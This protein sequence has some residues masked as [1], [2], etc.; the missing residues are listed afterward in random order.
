MALTPSSAPLVAVGLTSIKLRSPVEKG[1]DT[2]SGEAFEVLN[3][4]DFI[5]PLWDRATSHTSIWNDGYTVNK[6]IGNQRVPPELQGRTYAFVARNRGWDMKT[7][8]YLQV[9]FSYDCEVYVLLVNERAAV[10]PWVESKFTKISESKM[11]L[12]VDWHLPI[13]IKMMALMSQKLQMCNRAHLNRVQAELEVQA[14]CDELEAFRRSYG[15]YEECRQATASLELVLLLV[16]QGAELDEVACRY[17]L[18]KVAT[19]PE[20]LHGAG[21][22]DLRHLMLHYVYSRRRPVSSTLALAKVLDEVAVVRKAKH[23]EY[24]QVALTLRQL[25]MALVEKLDALEAAAA[26][27]AGNEAGAAATTAAGARAPPAAAITADVQPV[28][29]AGSGEVSGEA[30]A[31]ASYPGGGLIIP[32]GGAG[33]GNAGDADD[34]PDAIYA[35]DDAAAAV[36]DDAYFGC[37]AGCAKVASLDD[38]LILPQHT[39]VVPGAAAGQ[40]HQGHIGGASLPPS[41]NDMSPLDLA[42]ETKDVDFVSTSVVQGYLQRWWVGVDYTATALQ[43]T[44]AFGGWEHMTGWADYGTMLSYFD[45]HMVLRILQNAGFVGGLGMLAV[46]YMSY[47]VHFMMFSSRPFYD[48]PRGRWA[49]RLLCEAFFLYIFHSVQL[50]E[51]QTFMWQHAVL[52][53]HVA[54]MIVDEIYELMAFHEGRPVVYFRDGFNIIEGVTMVLLVCSGACKATTFVLTDGEDDSRYSELQTASDFLFNTASIFVW[55]RLLK[56]MI[57]LYDGMGS[58]LMVISKMTVEVL[59]FA[60][61]GVVIMLGV[62]FT[63]YATYRGRG[64]PG[65]D[66]FPNVML[67]LFRTFLGETMFD[68]ISDETDTLYVVYGTIVILLYAIAAAVVLANLLIALISSHFQPELAEAQSRLQR[69]DMVSSYNFMV[70]NQLLGA[71]FSL[72]LLVV[73][74]LLPSGMRPWAGDYADGWDAYGVLPMDGLPMPPETRKERRYPKGSR[75]L[76]YV[77]YLLTFYP[78]VMVLTWA[79]CILLMPYC[80]AYFALY[81][82]RNWLEELR[83]ADPEAEEAAESPDRPL[84]GAAPPQMLKGLAGAALGGGSGRLQGYP[85]AAAASAAPAAAIH[86]ITTTA[87]ERPPSARLHSATN[88][89]VPEKPPQPSQQSTPH[90]TMEDSAPSS[91]GSSHIMAVHAVPAASGAGPVSESRVHDA[92]PQQDT[93]A[94][95]RPGSA[96]RGDQGA[97]F[98]AA[99]AVG[100]VRPLGAFRAAL[101]WFFLGLEPRRPGT[102]GKPMWRRPGQDAAAKWQQTQQAQSQPWDHQERA[103][104]IA[105]LVLRTL[106][107]VTS[108]PVWLLLGLLLYVGVFGGLLVVAWGGLYQWVWRV[109]YY[110]HWVLRGWVEGWFPVLEKV[111][112]AAAG[113]TGPQQVSGAAAKDGKQGQ[114]PQPQ[115][116]QVDADVAAAGVDLAAWVGL[117]WAKRLEQRPALSPADIRGAMRDAGLPEGDVALAVKGAGPHWKEVEKQALEREHVRRADQGLVRR[118]TAVIREQL[119]ES[120]RE[121]LAEA[122]VVASSGLPRQL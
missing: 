1:A 23:K 108:R 72:P 99:G 121:A 38:V 54:S 105:W 95:V 33:A 82:Y 59:K 119:K 113:T 27:A 93:S 109:C 83:S 17:L 117:Q 87:S 104:S 92:P 78:A 74:E 34:D 62:A 6:V 29:K 51:H 7:D 36:A 56:F 77:I 88:K 118:L 52:V 9:K 24:T 111:P 25:A 32:G 28:V 63:M 16:K 68:T 55:A 47:L 86:H 12:K 100:G 75:E 46:R 101:A 2:S 91:S 44:M 19:N 26:G 20:A 42:C 71:P 76:P 14:V 89:V 79:A 69:A 48:S 3:T 98:A 80:L 102:S 64:I 103:A 18:H 30:A 106:A 122:G 58:L 22:R 49:F 107:Y 70:R 110:S 114:Q 37:G 53:L 84:G 35:A 4:S 40:Q 39:Q 41:L 96:T 66:S 120:V 8:D 94:V 65:M 43:V 73:T 10:P 15:V 31:A 60:L 50:A 61:P 13:H 115:F 85:S 116:Q 57:P 11:A 112:A 97:A 5:N 45:H 90:H 81:G 67:L 21:F